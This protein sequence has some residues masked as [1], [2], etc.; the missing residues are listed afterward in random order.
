[1]KQPYRY[2]SDELTHFVGRACS[3]DEHRYQT[4]LKILRTGKLRGSGPQGTTDETGGLLSIRGNGKISGETA[5]QPV[6]VCF[7]DIPISSLKLH[8]GKYTQFGIAFR[9]PFLVAM[10]ANPV[11]YVVNDAIL[12]G[13]HAI[14]TAAGNIELVRDISRAGL[15]DRLHS[16]AMAL[17]TKISDRLFGRPN[18][19][20]LKQ[21]LF[22]VDRLRQLL[23]Q[24]T[25]AFAK[26]FNSAEPEDSEK[27]YYLEREWRVFGDVCFQIS[28]VHR[29]ILPDAYVERFKEDR[30]DY[31]GEL[32]PAEDCS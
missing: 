14:P 18:D 7:C 21:L 5:I 3:N 30:P 24:T 23:Y 20:D 16:E 10:G 8:M 28:D 32:I 13:I 26:P 11:F 19:P 1:M 6:I 25:L 17:S 9:K 4:L 2:T 22:R 27:N 15:M 31:R 12:P 29:I